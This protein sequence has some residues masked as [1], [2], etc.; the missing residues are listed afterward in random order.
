MRPAQPPYPFRH[1]A[2]YEKNGDKRPAGDPRLAGQT[3]RHAG[4]DADRYD[5]ARPSG[6]YLPGDY[7]PGHTEPLNW[8]KHWT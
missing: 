7:V 8:V 4:D 5:G 2:P 3:V 6:A 1:L